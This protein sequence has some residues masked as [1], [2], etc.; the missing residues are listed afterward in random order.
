MHIA[1]SR[2]PP[3][4][5]ETGALKTPAEVKVVARLCA[6][7]FFRPATV[8]VTDA[9]GRNQ[10]RCEVC[11]ARKNRSGFTKEKTLKK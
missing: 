3:P 6:S 2:L 8:K 11:A 7:C 9:I 1:P 10:Y 5:A 4:D